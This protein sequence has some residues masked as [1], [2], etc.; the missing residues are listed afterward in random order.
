MKLLYLTPG[1]FDK[2][3]ISR[4]C[5]YQITALRALLGYSNVHV[6]S[7]LGPTPE[8]IEE[9]FEVDWFAAGIAPSQKLRYLSKVTSAVALRR[10]DVILSAHVR[11][12]GVARALAMVSGAKTVLNVYGVEVW[13]G[14][15]SDSYWG[16]K[17]ADHVISD[18]HFTARY[19]EA[20]RLRAPD[21]TVVVWDCVDTSKFSPGTPDADVLMEYGIPDPSTGCNLLTLGRMSRDAGHKGYERLLEA[22]AA[23]ASRAPGLRLIYAGRGDLVETLRRR[24]AAL[25]LAD[26]VFFTGA[27]HEDDLV[28]IYR[29]AHMFSLV[30]DRGFGR[31][32]G[33]PLTPLEAAACGCPILVGNQDGSQEAV[34]EG[35]NGYILDP[36]NAEL[37]VARILELAED[38]ALRRRLA[39][40]AV[41]RISEQFSYPGFLAKHRDLFATWFGT[42]Q[43]GREV[44]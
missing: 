26:R 24:A 41:R 18:C 13:S 4:Y 35:E 34:V 30:S 22:F 20:E 19:V 44:P 40:A 39:E 36:W 3:G 31:G 10:P 17:T 23:A 12:S 8:S 43:L 25:G 28:H 6:Y 2:G 29:S 7:L 1:C 9:P 11:L 38:V 32:E 42:D 27:I 33:I 21:S 14:F 37:H 5:R 15:R 16:L